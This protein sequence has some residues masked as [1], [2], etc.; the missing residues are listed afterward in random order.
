MFVGCCAAVQAVAVCT[1]H[2]SCP[3][4]PDIPGQHGTCTHHES[5]AVAPYFAGIAWYQVVMKSKEAAFHF[6]WS[7]G[8]DG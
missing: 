3:Y 2:Y 1:G 8:P 6:G 7:I 4:T 5:L